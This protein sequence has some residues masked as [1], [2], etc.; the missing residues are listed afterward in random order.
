MPR[1]AWSLFVFYM[2]QI[3]TVAARPLDAEDCDLP[4]EAAAA[5]S[6]DS[7][8]EPRAALPEDA[9][10][11]AKRA[12]TG[13][14]QLGAGFNSW[15][16]F[17]F[18]ALAAQS[19][20]FGTGNA[21]SLQVGLTGRGYDGHLRY[22]V[23]HLNGGENALRVELGAERFQRGAFVTESVG[24]RLQLARELAPGTRLSLGYTYGERNAS[25]EVLA[26]GKLLRGGTLSM[27]SL[28][29]V[30]EAATRGAH[31]DASILQ[32]ITLDFSSPETG[33]EIG[34]FR[35]QKQAEYLLTPHRLRGV[36]V[37]LKTQL[38]FVGAT[39]GE[40]VPVS[41]RFFVGGPGSVRGVALDSLGPALALPASPGDTSQRVV[42]GGTGMASASLEV[43]VPIGKRFTGYAFVDAGNAFGGVPSLRG[44]APES[45]DFGS[46]PL[47][48][49]AGLGLR[50][51]SPIGPVGVECGAPLD[52]K[53]GERPVLCSI[54]LGR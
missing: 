37:R 26:P 33:S 11:G 15:E 25:G 5:V 23:P 18:T 46:L 45:M 21:L 36:S 54:R 20:L 22:E 19:N 14:F 35:A 4:G 6:T 30:Q 16:R 34:I 51:N 31:A 42:I 32:R 48:T 24:G 2:S 41:E 53:P 12:P 38:G 8:G 52:P 17:S 9:P 40:E 50:W 29:L 28:G 1:L 13:V 27:L 7:D 10:R 44:M 39:D 3:D 43:E 49:S 47:R